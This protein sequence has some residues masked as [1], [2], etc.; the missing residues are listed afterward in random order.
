MTKEE[1]IDSYRRPKLRGNFILDLNPFTKLNFA[2]VI[3]LA[4]ALMGAYWTRLGAILICCAC[5]RL[6]GKEIFRKFFS[7]Y[8]KVFLLL[9]LFLVALNSAFRTGD[10]VY[11]EWWIITLTKEGFLYGLAMALLITEICGAI[12]AF[13]S[14]TPLKDI[15]YASEAVGASKSFSYIMLASMQSVIDLGKTA[16]KIMESQ[17]A[18]GV[19]TTGSLR[20]R[21]KALVPILFPLLLSSIAATEEKTVAMETRAFASKMKPTHLYELRRMPAPEKAANVAAIA[22]LAAGVVWRFAL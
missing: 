9:F 5:T 4:A 16:E 6:A 3:F 22:L 14:V 1:F 11:W 8:S 20:V 13:Y 21:F 12:M 18:R 17:S 10:T 19:E 7:L 15:M 2:F